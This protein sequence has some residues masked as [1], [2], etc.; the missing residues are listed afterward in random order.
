MD[1]RKHGSIRGAWVR[2]AI[3]LDT[4]EATTSYLNDDLELTS[5]TT[6]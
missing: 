5:G 1:R 2:A 4:Q 3:A 6:A